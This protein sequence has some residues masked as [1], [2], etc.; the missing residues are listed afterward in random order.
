MLKHTA[1]AA[2]LVLSTISAASAHDYNP[3]TDTRGIDARRAQEMQRIEE[4]RRTGQLSWREYFFLRREQSAIA[5]HERVA[6]ADGYVSPAE[7]AQLNREIDQASQDIHRLRTNNE[8][9]GWRRWRW[10]N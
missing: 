3:S 9:A 1:L 8:V 5:Q 2:A 10:W 6:K 4:G 7:R